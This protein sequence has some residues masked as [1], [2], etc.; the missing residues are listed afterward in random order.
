[1]LKEKTNNNEKEILKSKKDQW[2]CGWN[3]C[4]W[5]GKQGPVFLQLSI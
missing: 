2:E 5:N 3:E 1:M 4:G